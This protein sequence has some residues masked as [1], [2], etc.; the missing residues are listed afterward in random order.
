MGQVDQVNAET[1]IRTVGEIISPVTFMTL[2]FLS[3]ATGVFSTLFQ[4]AP[5]WFIRVSGNR[6]WTSINDYDRLETRKIGDKK[7]SIETFPKTD[8]ELAELEAFATAIKGANPYP[9][10]PDEAV[11][12]TAVFEAIVRSVETGQ[13]VD[14]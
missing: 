9:I 3:G 6:G 10:S 11:H 12:G 8:I 2:R 13:P 14:V 7:H 1:R 5:V 4:T